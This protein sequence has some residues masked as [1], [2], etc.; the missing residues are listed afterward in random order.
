MEKNVSALYETLSQFHESVAA[1]TAAG[2]AE[3]EALQTAPL[4]T[5]RSARAGGRKASYAEDAPGSE[6]DDD[7]IVCPES[8]D[9]YDEAAVAGLGLGHDG[10]DSSDDDDDDDSDDEE[11]SDD[12]ADEE[13]DD[14][15]RA[16]DS[17]SSDSDGESVESD[18]SDVPAG[19]FVV[20]DPLLVKG[21]DCAASTDASADADAD[22]VA[23]GW[24]PA[25][26]VEFDG[27]RGRYLLEL[28]RDVPEPDAVAKPADNV[29][30]WVALNELPTTA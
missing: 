3:A 27:E 26:V 30:V 20:G 22:A 19:N 13:A 9:E 12:E 10:S 7:E 29:K 23:S 8:G 11:D 2:T 28:E 1:E 5:R 4:A 24:I 21:L 15:A 17:N 6:A 16:A 14:A 25:T 18:N